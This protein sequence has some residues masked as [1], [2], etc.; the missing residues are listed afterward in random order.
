[1]GKEI[2]NE[3]GRSVK[4]G[5]GLFVNRIHDFN[6]YETRAKMA[7]PFPEGCF[8]CIECDKRLELENYFPS[9]KK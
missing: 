6:D 8:I 7:K 2:C 5:S 1:M 4:P 9:F 3:C